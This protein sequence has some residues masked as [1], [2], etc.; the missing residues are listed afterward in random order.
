ML[1][2]EAC[3]PIGRM[4]YQAKA[5]LSL[6]GAAPKH[7]PRS[8]RLA[9]GQLLDRLRPGDILVVWRLDRL[10][11]PLTASG[12]HRHQPGRAQH[13]VRNLQEATEIIT[14]GRKLVFHVLASRPSSNA[15]SPHPRTNGCGA[16][17]R[18]CLR[19]LRRPAVGAVPREGAV[20]VL[21][22]LYLPC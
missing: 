4:T 16:G 2:P 3:E 19:P 6:G 20:A 22:G 15:T 12:R 11:R 5:R 17:R 18:P 7:A 13:R 9:H 21:A 8:D 1:V 10:G 14:P